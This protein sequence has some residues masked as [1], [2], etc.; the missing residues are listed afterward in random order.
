M[1]RQS[2]L[3]D[4]KE[5]LAL[6][7]RWKRDPHRVTPRRRRGETWVRNRDLR[8]G[9]VAHEVTRGVARKGPDG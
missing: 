3:E 7:G 4:R 6:G 8:K 1:A 2:G 5:R 9:M